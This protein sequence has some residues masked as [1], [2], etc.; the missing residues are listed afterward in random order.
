MAMAENPAFFT[1]EPWGYRIL[2]SWVA[3][4]L[5]AGGLVR[6][7]LWSTLGGLVLAGALLFLFFRRLGHGEWASLLAVAAF[8]LSAPA[9]WPVRYPF[10]GEPVCVALE[11]ALLLALES[12]GSASVLALVL[13]LGALSKEM[14]LLFLPGVYLAL[15]DRQGDRRALATTALAGLPAVMGTVLLRY[16][17]G[18]YPPSDGE[19]PLPGELFAALVRIVEALP[20]WWRPVL[21]AGVT[22]LAC[23]GALRSAARPYLRRYGYLILLSFML[24]LAAAVYTGEGKPGIF[25]SLDVPRLTLYTLPLVLP[26]ALHALDRVWPHLWTPP[27]VGAPPRLV[28]AAAG[29][30]SV[31]LALLPALLVDRY[32]RVDLS[33]E[34]DGPYVLTALRETL[35]IAARLER[36]QSVS[37]DPES[38]RYI[39]GVDP[40]Q[41]MDRM[42]WFLRDG[43]GDKPYYGTRDLAMRQARASVLLPCFRPQPLDLVLLTDAPREERVRVVVNGA[44]IGDL[45]VASERRE[46]TLRIPAALLFRGDNL[47]GF[48]AERFEKPWVLRVHELTLKPVG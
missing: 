8:G 12:G 9:G 22:P 40:P 25:F 19:A 33:H 7:F 11:M 36:G 18:S 15:R 48:F 2:P 35:R 39:W 5:P 46:A 1:V 26:L 42:R 38:R 24:P 21:L 13:V 31:G 20:L 32:R 43:W 6:G 30:A 4:A 14:F 27:P 41:E 34:R 17:W 29:L 44:R 10:L 28:G 16:V 23:L 45:E 47:I 37:W 3:R